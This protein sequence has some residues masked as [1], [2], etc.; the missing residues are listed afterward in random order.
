MD[1]NIW[2]IK[3]LLKKKW[4]WVLGVCVGVYFF[5]LPYQKSLLLL[6]SNYEKIKQLFWKIAALYHSVFAITLVF[7]GI[8]QLINSETK[9]LFSKNNRFVAIIG[10]GIFIVYEILVCPIYI[11]YLIVYSN[12]IL[13]FLS[14]ILCETIA[15]I[16][17]GYISIILK[18][19]L[20]GYLVVFLILLVFFQ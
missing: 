11:W 7:Q 3:F 2:M 8:I 6:E 16:V 9:D 12:E 10:L 20:V 15:F 14:M 4:L 19:P 1:N 5:V 13:Y 18:Q 17:F